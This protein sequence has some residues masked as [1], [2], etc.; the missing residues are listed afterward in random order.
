[1]TQIQLQQIQLQQD[2]AILAAKELK[3]IN[4]YQTALLK[5]SREVNTFFSGNIEAAYKAASE[6]E[7]RLFHEKLGKYEALVQLSEIFK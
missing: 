7:K 4:G 6:E 2:V 5:A 3:I 1:M